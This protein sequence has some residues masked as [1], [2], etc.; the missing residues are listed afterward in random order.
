[1]IFRRRLL[2]LA[3]LSGLQIWDCTNLDSIT[4]LLNVSSSE[5]G[6]VL[7]AEI[8]PTPTATGDEF[9]NLRPVLGIMCGY[10]LCPLFSTNNSLQC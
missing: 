10:T 5:W 8:L 1:M 9:L 4:E 6:H 3:Y 2:I 7:H